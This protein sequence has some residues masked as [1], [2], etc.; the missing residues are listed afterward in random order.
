MYGSVNPQRIWG[1]NGTTP[2]LSH[3]TLSKQRSDGTTLKDKNRESIK[4]DKLGRIMEDTESSELGK[5]PG[6]PEWRNINNKDASHK[7][8]S[9]DLLAK[10]LI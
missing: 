8:V 9:A 7:S 1:E 10:M 3:I 5:M 2:V 6:A 4:Q